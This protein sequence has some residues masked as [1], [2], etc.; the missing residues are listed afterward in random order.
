MPLAWRNLRQ[1]IRRMRSG[2]TAFDL[3]LKTMLVAVF[4]AIVYFAWHTGAL[5]DPFAEAWKTTLGAT[6]MFGGALY[7]SAMLLVQL[8]RVVLV[9]FYRPQ[10]SLSDEALPSVTV[11]IPA[12]NEGP[13]VAKSIE[14]IARS[15]YPK[16]KLQIIAIDDGSTDDTWQHMDAMAKRYPSLVCAI[17]METNGG[18]RQGLRVGFALAAGD[19]LVTM[20]SDSVVERDALRN[21]VT[22]LASDKRIGAVAGNVKVQNRS[23]G[24]L[25]R[26]MRASFVIAFDFTRAYQSMFRSVLCT[27]GAFSAYRRSV[28]EKVLPDWNNQTWCGK[29][30]TIAEDR[31]LTNLILRE[32]HEI[33]FQS[34]A[35]VYTNVPT[36]YSR[37]ARMYQRWERGNLRENVN[38]AKFC[39]S[40]KNKFRKRFWLAANV[41]WMLSCLDM[42]VP[43][44][45]IVASLFYGFINPFFALK[46]LGYIVIFSTIMQA[47]Y[48]ARERD[49]DFI[50]G[51]LYSIF[52]FTCFWWVVPYSVITAGNGDWMTR[53]KKTSAAVEVSGD[54]PTRIAA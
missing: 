45:L 14:S 9:I 48:I 39:F 16:E 49:T 8:V 44:I 41:E 36:T 28:V 43:Y 15:N 35:V 11:I 19:V 18:K 23:A 21:L 27:P 54:L 3:I 2:A 10:K 40:T 50:Y 13:D 53:G 17:R 52:W 30:S 29:A 47:F 22:P 7:A 1:G 12:Y 24:I 37:M 5:V 20:D 51:I 6:L 33:V 42:V 46:Y 25:P 31:A 38:Y 4:A 34:N 32:G 26:M